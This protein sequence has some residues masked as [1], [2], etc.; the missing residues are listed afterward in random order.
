MGDIKGERGGESEK[1]SI[2]QY[3]RGIRDS[4]KLTKIR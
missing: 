1:N 3:K 2:K 4:R